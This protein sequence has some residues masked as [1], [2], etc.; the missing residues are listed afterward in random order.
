MSSCRVNAPELPEV[1]TKVVWATHIADQGQVP[2]TAVI[3]QASDMR[4]L[5]SGG[6]V[7]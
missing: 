5:H 1:T 7:G 3:G 2:R 6:V 4:G